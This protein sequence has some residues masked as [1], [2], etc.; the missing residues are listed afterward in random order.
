MGSNSLR[1]DGSGC[2]VVATVRVPNACK[3]ND[4]HYRHTRPAS[5]ILSKV[6]PYVRVRADRIFIAKTKSALPSSTQPT[7]T[8][9]LNSSRY[10]VAMFKQGQILPQPEFVEFVLSNG[11]MFFF[12]RLMLAIFFSVWLKTGTGSNFKLEII[13]WA[14]ISRL[15]L[16]GM[17][18]HC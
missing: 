10:P 14:R 8:P 17:F 15:L 7:N 9:C 11:Q 18:A 13:V 3:I 1:F 2:G 5:E 4:T 6:K 12:L 16:V